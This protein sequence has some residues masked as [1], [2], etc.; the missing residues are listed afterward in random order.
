MRDGR[1]RA[2]T[3]PGQPPGPDAAYTS[4]QATVAT[5]GQ[6]S[7]QLTPRFRPAGPPR[8]MSLSR[9]GDFGPVFDRDGGLDVNPRDLA[10]MHALDLPLLGGIILVRVGSKVLPMQGVFTRTKLQD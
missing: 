5:E 2:G 4:G 3:G 6:C 10:G 7:L 1:R 8:R 9:D